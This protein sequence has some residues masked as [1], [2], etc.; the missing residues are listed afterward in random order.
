MHRPCTVY[1]SDAQDV[2]VGELGAGMNVN[3]EMPNIGPRISVYDTGGE[4]KARI[5][6][7]GYGR[8]PGQFCA[9]HGICV[10]SR[11]DIYVGE[12][13]WTNATNWGDEPADGIRSFQKLVRTG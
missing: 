8:G 10:D 1:V 6:D 2:Y 7:L 13:A 12:V 9:P 4:R 11:G 5:G 3:R